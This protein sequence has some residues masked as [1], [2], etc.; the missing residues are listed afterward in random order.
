MTFNKF[1]YKYQDTILNHIEDTLR[2]LELPLKVET[3]LI[4]V[5]NDNLDEILEH[6]FEA[7]ESQNED[8][9]YEQY[10]N[11]EI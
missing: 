10:K 6:N 9:K 7:V 8:D 5:V 11:G 1:K 3:R 2:G 4:D